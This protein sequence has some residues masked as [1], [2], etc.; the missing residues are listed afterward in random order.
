MN[1]SKVL[2]II[3][4]YNKG[5]IIEKTIKSILNQSYQDFELIIIDDC[6]SDN[7]RE[8][9]EKFEDKRIK[10]IK[11]EK[12]SGANK[13]RNIGIQ[14]ARYEL[15]AF[16]DSNEEWYTRKLEKQLKYLKSE[17]FDIVSCKY[18]QYINDKFNLIPVENIDLSKSLLNKI[19]YENFISTQTI[20]G[21]KMFSDRKIW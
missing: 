15:I 10:Y 5:Y 19:L 12:N 20:L 3:P 6:S 2:I 8:V 9:I 14:N 17:D 1:E 16:H 4:T 13:A 21:K 18:N 11:L 7:T